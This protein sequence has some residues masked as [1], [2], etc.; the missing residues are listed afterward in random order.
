MKNSILFMRVLV[1]AI[2]ANASSAAY[3]APEAIPSSARSLYHVDLARHFFESP[4]KEESERAQFRAK[5]ALLESFKEKVAASPSALLAALSAYED[6]KTSY[7]RHESYLYLRAAIDVEDRASSSANAALG[8][9]YAARTAFLRHE[10]AAIDAKTLEQFIE[11]TPGLAK[12]RFAVEDARRSRDHMLPLAQEELLQSQA[13]W[14]VDWQY[15]LYRT[16]LARTK[17][18]V[19][20]TAAGPLD[21]QRDR[22]AIARHPDAA[23][24]ESG[25]RRRMAAY[26]SQRDLYAFALSKLVQARNERALL[27]GFSD[28]AEARYFES[29]WTRADVDR[30]LAAVQ[31]HAASYKRYQR[32]RADKACALRGLKQA[33]VWDVDGALSTLEEPFITI[34]EA[35]AKIRAALAPLGET[36][37]RAMASLLDPKNGR[38]DIAPGERRAPGGFSLGYVGVDSVFY[39]EGYRGAYNDMRILTHEATHAV[40]RQ[41]MT[42]S[43]VSALYADG[44]KYLFES[45]AIL[46]ELLLADHLAEQASSAPE[47]EYYLEQFLEG[48]GTIAFVAAPEAEL[49]QAIYEAER[50]GEHL[51]ADSIDALTLE[52][53]S[54]YSIWPQ[55]NRELKSKWMTTVLMYQDPFY[56][57][58]YV[59][60]GIL[61]L[62]YYDIYRSDPASFAQ[63]YQELL[64]NGFDAP[65][66]ELL[67]EFLG[68]DLRDPDAL[69]ARAMRV[70]N[71]K[72]EEYSTSPRSTGK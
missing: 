50:K 31:R 28:D 14:T 38:L 24:R 20:D 45:F 49:E 54:R 68:I 4:Q 36:F 7:I 32:V 35:S 13:P 29:Y 55:I 65:P 56:N 66:E 25:F 8:A 63:R 6:V 51:S 27:H 3:A 33:N 70:L 18:G 16:L 47:R 17:F 21:V 52:V 1:L 60:G 41:L 46:S 43:G 37:G 44:P 11:R 64:R 53:Y 40:H 48:K 34:D 30:L 71:E 23:V 9:E 62:V 19:V 72:I 69:V 58:N 57:I 5:L 15:L 67:H 42:E 59:W 10:L 61:A 26:D 12:Y 39:M 2:L 22:R